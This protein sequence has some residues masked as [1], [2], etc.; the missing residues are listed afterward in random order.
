M[1]RGLD[2]M[3]AYYDDIAPFYDLELSERRDIHF[4]L[5]LTRRLRPRAVLDAGAGTGRVT[6]PLARLLAHSGGAVW[7]LDLSEAMLERARQKVVQAAD[8]RLKGHVHIVRADLRTFALP[9]CFELV[10]AT[11][12][13]FAHM[14]DDADLLSALG[15]IRRHLRPGGWFVVEQPVAREQ[16]AADTSGQRYVV[17]GQRAI[18]RGQVRLDVAMTQEYQPGL[19]VGQVTCRYRLRDE[20]GRER[21]AGASFASRA[22]RMEDWMALCRAAG[23]TVDCCWGGFDFA[24]FD[25][26]TSSEL[27]VAA[28]APGDA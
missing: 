11:N 10:L 20:A 28:R 4:W 5:T 26:A 25:A 6:L 21:A 2:E 24:P 18:R 19:P 9:A 22:R 8:P 13:P 14:A 12:N 27:I 15:A 3:Q 7:A 16:E 23:L 1:R 17:E